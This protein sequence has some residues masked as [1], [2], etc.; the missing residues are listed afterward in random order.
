[1]VLS[2]DALLTPVTAVD[3]FVLACLIDASTGMILAAQEN[4]S[5]ISMPTAAAGAT[6]IASAIS[7]LT[8][9]LGTDD[10]LEDVLLAFG[11]HFF[12][13]RLVTAD[14]EPRILALVILDRLKTNIALARREFR[15]FCAG[16]AS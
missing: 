4:Q 13:I 1:V 9:R 2:A 11:K 3:G 16:L 14:P 8:S 5:G 15:D 7:L 6:D 12:L 10:E